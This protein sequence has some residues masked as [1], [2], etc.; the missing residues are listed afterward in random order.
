MVRRS[1]AAFS[2]TS[3]SQ[4]AVWSTKK[5]QLRDRMPDPFSHAPKP[6]EPLRTRHPP[7]RS[8]PWAWLVCLSPHVSH[9]PHLAPGRTL[10]NGTSSSASTQSMQRSWAS[11]RTVPPT[12]LWLTLPRQPTKHAATHHPSLSATSR[13][14]GL[15]S[16]SR[17]RAPYRRFGGHG[18]GRPRP[19]PHRSSNDRSLTR[20]CQ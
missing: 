17:H 16:S 9:R 13:Q 2:R 19:L 6:S 14:H 3:P 11:T 7:E 15:R 10:L 20:F 1:V 8:S 5:V 12:H 18:D 4:L